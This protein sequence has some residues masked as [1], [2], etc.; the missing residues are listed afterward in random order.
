MAKQVQHNNTV[1]VVE[2]DPDHYLLFELAARRAGTC[3][4]FRHATDG[5][6]AMQYLGGAGV[7]ADRGTHPLP[8]MIL[9][10][11]KMPRMNGLELLQWVR[12][13]PLLK[14]IPFI[15]LSSSSLASDINLAYDQGVSSYLVK[16]NALDDLVQILSWVT[17]YWMQVNELPDLAYYHRDELHGPEARSESIHR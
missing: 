7:F 12:L 13:Q 6:E 5:N 9:S 4:H 11:L 17:H 15:L 3:A 14:R 10:D 2:D 16:P 1:L 8:A